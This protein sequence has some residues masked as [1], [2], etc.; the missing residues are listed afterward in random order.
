MPDRGAGRGH[1]VDGDVVVRQVVVPFAEQHQRDLLRPVAQVV[2]LQLDGAED[3]TVDDPGPEALTDEDLLFAAAA[4]VV[5]QHDEIVSGGGVDDGGRQFREVGVA[6]FGQCEGD[7]A[8]A[9]FT[10]MPG[11]QVGPVAEHVDGPL[12]PLAHG[13]CDVLVVVHHVGDGLDGDPRVR[14]NVL[15]ADPHG[16]PF[17]ASRP[18]LP[19]RV[20]GRH[21]EPRTGSPTSL[22]QRYTGAL[23]ALTRR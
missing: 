2:E 22:L 12:D 15:E 20:R 7:D 23:V 16:N 4:R 3:E 17:P 11:G 5:Q 18:V 13:R 10:Q 19:V 21:R 14:G 9:P 8:G 1:V 6:E